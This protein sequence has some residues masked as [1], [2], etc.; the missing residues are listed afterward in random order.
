VEG[1]LKEYQ[2]AASKA[3]RV[4]KDLPA[5]IAVMRAAIQFASLEAQRLPEHRE[6]LLGAAKAM[7]YNLGANTWPGWNE[8]GIQPNET[9]RWF[10]KDAARLN[11]RLAIELDRGPVPLCNAHWLLGAHALADR[12]LSEAIGQF[13]LGRD[14]AVSAGRGDLEWMCRGYIAIAGDGHAQTV[15]LAAC[16]DE[17]K[18]IGTDDANF[19]A[20]QLVQVAAWHAEWRGSR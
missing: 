18:A 1:V 2:V 5:M 9:D 3:Y 10:G 19:F 16:V 7:A 6:R 12:L 4:D 17:L 13:E 11:L 20:A 15:E 14:Y 8:D